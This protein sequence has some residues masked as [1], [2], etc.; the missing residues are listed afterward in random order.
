MKLNCDWNGLSSSSFLWSALLQAE[1]FAT[2][3]SH[4]RARSS[5]E[6]I[7]TSKN[8]FKGWRH[9]SHSTISSNGKYLLASFT[10]QNVPVCFYLR[11]AML[12]FR[13]PLLQ[14]PPSR[15]PIFF[16]PHYASLINLKIAWNGCDFPKS[17]RWISCVKL[18][19]FLA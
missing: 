6:N 19:F 13:R 16:L 17:R 1:Y 8:T 18:C 4:I 15:H 3:F 9:G 14:P 2:H 11:R 7:H 5:M 10:L 12:T